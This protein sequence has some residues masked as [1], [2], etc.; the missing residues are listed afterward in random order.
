[1]GVG[2]GAIEVGERQARRARD[3]PRDG[4]GPGRSRFDEART[5]AGVLAR[6]R[7]IPALTRHRDPRRARTRRGRRHQRRCRDRAPPWRA[8]GTG[9][10][11]RSGAVAFRAQM[12]QRHSERFKIVKIEESSR[13]AARRASSAVKIQAGIGDLDFFA[14]D[15]SPPQPWHHN[16]SN[17]IQ[18][19]EIELG[20]HWRCPQMESRTD[21]M[22]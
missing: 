3:R 17:I 1:M 13:R 6:W 9:S 2:D 11:R 15:R 14:G 20:R 22:L 10:P 19:L 21:I 12:R 16:A 4:R 7:D 5:R 18:A 8:W